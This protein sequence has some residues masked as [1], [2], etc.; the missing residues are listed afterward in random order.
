MTL[1]E[2]M[3]L[4][5]AGSGGAG[6]DVWNLATMSSNA[7]SSQF[8]QSDLDVTSS[9]PPVMSDD[10]TKLWLAGT[11]GIE[12]VGTGFRVVLEYNLARPYDLYSI[13]DPATGNVI[14]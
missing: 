11:S 9:I 7:V 5:S 3:L 8:I 1:E 13:V 6:G 10:G 12:L 4:A 14:P 2:L